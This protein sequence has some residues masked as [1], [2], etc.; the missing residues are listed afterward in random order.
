M[1]IRGFAGYGGAAASLVNNAGGFTAVLGEALWKK[2]NK[3][4]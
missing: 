2:I 3:E 1:P 4:S